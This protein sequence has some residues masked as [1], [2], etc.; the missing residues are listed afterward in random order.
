MRLLARL[1]T[2][3]SLEDSLTFLIKKNTPPISTQNRKINNRF[4]TFKTKP[5]IVSLWT[6]N[7]FLTNLGKISQK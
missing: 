2:R 3:G 4:Q 6:L 5:L 7:N 1:N